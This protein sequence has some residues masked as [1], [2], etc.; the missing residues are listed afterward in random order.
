M[1]LAPSKVKEILDSLG[2]KTA[3]FLEN[4]E[5]SLLFINRRGYSPISMCE[6]CGKIDE[7]PKC[8]SNLVFYRGSLKLKCHHCSHQEEVKEACSVCEGKKITIGHGTEKI[9][10]ELEQPK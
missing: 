7:C 9:E 6:K 5:Q 1:K 4:G 2:F 10:E 3:E 8:E